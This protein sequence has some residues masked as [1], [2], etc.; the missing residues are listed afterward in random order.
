MSK[1]SKTLDWPSK[2]SQFFNVDAKP[3][4][5]QMANYLIHEVGFKTHG[6]YI[7][8]YNKGKYEEVSNELLKKTINNLTNKRAK[9]G[10]TRDFFDII[11]TQAQVESIEEVT[12]PERCLNLEN[13]LYT[14]DD[15]EFGSHMRENFFLHKMPVKFDRDAKC[16][17]FIEF[18]NQ[19][20]ENDQQLVNVTAEIFGYCLL[21]GDP[22]LHKAFV[23]YGSGRNGKST[24][25]DILKELMGKGNYASVPMNKL[26]DPF[27]AF[28]LHGKLA[29]ITGELPTGKI[30]SDDF[31]TV[32][33]GEEIICSAKYKD[34][35]S[36][37]VRAKMI[38][39]CNLFP[40]F[41]DSTPGMREKLLFMP[42]NNYLEE[43]DR[44]V[45]LFSKL[46]IEMSGILNFALE[47]LDRILERGRLPEVDAA[48]E[49]MKKYRGE[50]DS[51]YL[52]FEVCLEITQFKVK[53]DE[54]IPLKF[55]YGRYQLFC[56][57]EGFRQPIGK[58][59]F[60]KK[61]EA[62]LIEKSREKKWYFKEKKGEFLKPFQRVFKIDYAI[63]DDAYFLG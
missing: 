3:E 57:E 55:L 20:F 29:N 33:G 26:G 30:S 31:K 9:P 1:M 48:K 45:K 25:L 59:K 42:F 10:Q 32:V 7:Y 8:K 19:T 44:D 52:F 23:L 49:V 36:L 17:Q 35:F 34:Q 62:I 41:N 14:I 11:T 43:H 16:P 24:W 15:K 63:F 56:S 53:P 37:R 18:L 21:G 39:A 28:G 13:G 40:V 38:F 60:G 27:S 46:K 47:G 5:H 22:F 54:R 50:S 61:I 12:P 6:K 4:Y 2:D 58:G 51:V